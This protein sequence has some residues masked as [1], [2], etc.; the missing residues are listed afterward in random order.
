MQEHVSKFD[1]SWAF[2][3]LK[4]VGSMEDLHP[5]QALTP[6]VTLTLTLTQIQH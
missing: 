6:T 5:P 2:E 3:Q 1:E 4:R